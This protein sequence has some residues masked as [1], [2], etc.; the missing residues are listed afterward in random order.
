MRKRLAHQRE[1]VKAE[2]E[3]EKEEEKEE[4]EE[5]GSPSPAVEEDKSAERRK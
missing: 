5:S 4:G 2:E 3:E 1:V